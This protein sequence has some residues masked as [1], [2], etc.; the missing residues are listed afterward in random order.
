MGTNGSRRIIMHIDMDAFFASVEQR[1]NPHYRGK[2]I[3]VIGSGKRTVVTTASYEARRFSIKTGMTVPEA[4]K[5]CPEMIFVVGNNEKYTDTCVRIVSILKQYSPKLEVYSIDES[6]LDLSDCNRD[7]IKI[8][9]EI[10]EKIKEEV[11]LTCSIGIGPNKLIAKLASDMKKPD[12]LVRIRD[13]EVQKLFETLPVE[14]LCGIGDKT[15]A[16]LLTL[17][18][19]TCKDLGSASTS[20]LRKKFGIIGEALKLMGQGIDNSPIIPSEEAPE[21]KSIGH[22][23]TMEKDETDTIRLKKYLLQLSEMVGRRLRRESMCGKTIHLTIRYSDFETFSK[24]RTVEEYIKDTSSIYDAAL[25]IFDS[26][27]LNKA[28]RLLG[29]SISNL[30]KDLQIP[31]FNEEK[32]ENELTKAVDKINDAYGDFSVTRASLLD[33]YDHKGVI[34][35]SWR[36]EK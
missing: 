23:M 8:A 7:P 17:G 2:P 3:A 24:Q 22:S 31:L 1:C 14:E 29:V 32:K 34:S 10:K 12:G 25:K 5:L 9:K 35:P 28:V 33:K 36:P 20:L 30:R 21:A 19:K 6:F 18:I 4:R 15:K 11:G 27:K 16:K 26:I 13:K